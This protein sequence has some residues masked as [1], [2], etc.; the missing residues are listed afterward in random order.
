MREFA[1]MVYFFCGDTSQVSYADKQQQ[2]GRKAL[3]SGLLLF[4]FYKHS[5]QWFVMPIIILL[6]KTGILKQVIHPL[7]IKRKP[8]WA[9]ANN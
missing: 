3:T 2:P 8:R 9:T 5:D 6:F 4:V 1:E 7:F